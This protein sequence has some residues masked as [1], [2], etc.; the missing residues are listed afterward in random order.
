MYLLILIWVDFTLPPDVFRTSLQP[1]HQYHLHQT[2]V[3][4]QPPL[5]LKSSTQS[6]IIDYYGMQLR[7]CWCA[8]SVHF[9]QSKVKI[10]YR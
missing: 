10:G 3:L 2:A 4:V 9:L 6:A 5:L 7:K 1:C 8:K